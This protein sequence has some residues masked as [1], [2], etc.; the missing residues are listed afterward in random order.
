[1]AHQQYR[2]DLIFG[3]DTGQAINNINQLNTLLTSIQ[4]HTTVGIDG[5]SIQQAV[6]AAKE[7]QVHLNN[8]VNVNTG[9][10]DL[11]KFS[12]S[13][14]KAGTDLSTL[15]TK[16]QAAG[17]AGQQAFVKIANAVSQAQV[18]MYQ[19]SGAM[20][21]FAT[22]LLNT[23]K[24]Q[25]ASTAIHGVVGAIKSA[26][27]YT[28]DLNAALNDIQIV[29][30]AGEI[31]MSNFA[32]KAAEAARALNTT[33]TEYAKAAL[34]FYQQG[35]SGDAVLERTNTVIKLAQ[36]TGQSAAMVSDQMTAIWNN[37]DDGSKSLEHYADVLTKLG[38]STASSTD[39]ISVGLQKFAAVA[40]TVGLNYETAA[41]AVA[42]V[43]AETRQSAEVVG[44]S[45]K[46]IFARMESLKLGDTLED[47]VDLNKYTEALSAVGVN[48]LN[49]KGQLRDM[50]DILNELGTKWQG[51]SETT[52]IAL[53]QTVGGIRQYNQMIALMDNW[54]KVEENVEL[55]EN[56]GGELA[57]QAEIWSNSYEGAAE[58]LKQAKNDLYESLIDDST[59]IGF[60]NVMAGLINKI[61][62]FIDS[63]GGIGPVILMLVGLFSK[64]LLP[65]VTSVFTRAGNLISVTTGKALK[66]TIA[67]QEQMN[68]K[69]QESLNSGNYTGAQQE[70]LRLSNELLQVKQ[71]MV[72]AS[73]NASV[74][75]QKEMEA[76]VAAYEAVNLQTQ[77]IYEQI[78]A[79]ES[80]K[81][82]Q[83]G[84]VT[85][86][87]DRKQMFTASV[88]NKAREAGVSEETIQ[89]ATTT[90]ISDTQSKLANFN[91]A[92]YSQ[93]T[94]AIQSSIEESKKRINALIEE[95][96]LKESGATEEIRRQGVE[97][98]K[99]LSAEQENLNQLMAKKEESVK[100]DTE[101]RE[102]L[103]NI[104]QLQQDI[105]N[106]I[107]E[108][109]TTKT[110][111]ISVGTIKTQQIE[112]DLSYTTSQD[113][114]VQAREKQKAA[115]GMEV[116]REATQAAGMTGADSGEIDISLSN[117]EKLFEAIQKNKNALSEYKATM[118]D[119]TAMLSKTSKNVADASNTQKQASDRLKK[120][121]A[122]VNKL[123][124]Q[125][126]KSGKAYRAAKKEVAAAT[127]EY[128]A[129]EEKLKTVQE[130][131]KNE[132]LQSIEGF[133]KLASSMNLPKS[134][135]DE[136]DAKFKKLS[137]SEN[138]TEQDILEITSIFERAGVSATIA[139]D[140]MEL[141]SADMLKVLAQSGMSEEALLK[142]ATILEKMGAKG[143][144]AANMLRQLAGEFQKTQ[145]YSASMQ[146]ALTGAIQG[147]GT[148]AG[149]AMMAYTGFSMF[150]KIFD[151]SATPAEKF[152]NIMMS[153]SML[154]PIVA[155]SLKRI[156]AARKEENYLTVASI[157]AKTKENIQMAIANAQKEKGAALTIFE[158]AKIWLHNAAL[159]VKNIL[160][161]PVAGAIIVGIALATAAAIAIGTSNQEKYNEQLKKTNEMNMEQ[162]EKTNDLANAWSEQMD[163]MDN[164]IAK[165]EDLK[166]AGED[167]KDVVSDIV[168]QVP[169]MV[170]AYRDLAKGLDINVGEGSE[171]D[172][173][174]RRLE[175]AA[176][177]GDI[178]KIKEIQNELDNL[179][180][181]K[182]AENADKG[183]QS[184][185]IS[186]AMAMRDDGGASYQNNQVTKTVS[187]STEA[188]ILSRF[189]IGTQN[190]SN[191][192]IK[193]DADNASNFI[194]DYEN[195][196]KAKTE[197]ENTMGSNAVNS[198]AYQDIV[199]LLD[200]SSEQYD[201][202]T[203]LQEASNKYKVYEAKERLQRQ[204]EDISNIK[205][206]KD[207]REYRDKL[208]NEVGTDPVARQAAEDWLKA[209]EYLKE[210][211]DIESKLEYL[212]ETT[213]KDYT[214]FY[215]NLSPD[216]QKYFAQINFNEVQSEE[217]IRGEIERLRSIAAE[218]EIDIKIKGVGEIK[219]SVSKDMTMED[220]EAIRNNE[221]IGWG[222]DGIIQFEEFIQLSYQQQLDYLDKIEQEQQKRKSAELKQRIS[223]EEALLKEL[224][225][226]MESTTDPT[227]LKQ[228]NAEYER[229]FN[230]L[231]KD[232]DDDFL[233]SNIISN[234]ELNALE[235]TRSIL[236]EISDLEFGE[237]ISEEDYFNIVNYNKE[238]AKYFQLTSEGY[239]MVGNPL[240][241]QQEV[242]STI[243]E[244][245]K[246]II[247]ESKNKYLSAAVTAQSLS[248]Y[249]GQEKKEIGSHMTDDGYLRVNELY[250]M[251]NHMGIENS[252]NS[253]TGEKFKG[254][255]HWTAGIKAAED[256]GYE[257]YYDDDGNY[258]NAWKAASQDKQEATEALRGQGKED[259]I[260]SNLGYQ[261]NYIGESLLSN[262]SELIT[263]GDIYGSGVSK[264]MYTMELDP[265]YVQRTTNITKFLEQE[266]SK[267]VL[268]EENW[269][270]LNDY[271]WSA[272]NQNVTEYSGTIMSTPT[273]MHMDEESAYRNAGYTKD[274]EVA[275]FSAL[276]NYVNTVWAEESSKYDDWVEQKEEAT[277]AE[278][279]AVAASDAVATEFEN[280]WSTT[281]STWNTN[282]DTLD[283]AE[284]TMKDEFQTA[285]KY[286]NELFNGLKTA[287]ERHEAYQKEL[288]GLTDEQKKLLD[289]SN[290]LNQAYWQSSHAA[291]EQ[292]ASEGLDVA[293]WG[294]YATYLE[295][296]LNLKEQLA[297]VKIN[298]VLLEGEEL[299][300]YAEE[301][302][303]DAA[304]S[305]MKMNKGITTLSSNWKEWSKTLKAGNAENGKS[306]KNSQLY[307]KT[308]SDTKTALSDVLDVSEEFITM[309]FIT[310]AENLALIEKA[311]EGDAEAIDALGR[312]LSE[313]IVKQS[314]ALNFAEGET[315]DNIT[316]LLE[317]VSKALDDEMPSLSLA[318]VI[319]NE[320]V[321]FQKMQDVVTAAKMTME[322]ANAYYRSM[323][324]TPKYKV[325]TL[326]QAN[327]IPITK[328]HHSRIYDKNSKDPDTGEYTRWTDTEQVE[329]TT[330]S[331]SEFKTAF[332]SYGV[333]TADGQGTEP[334]TAEV[335]EEEVT[336]QTDEVES[337]VY[338]G[339]GSFSDL[340]SGADTSGDSSSSDSLEE[341]EIKDDDPYKEINDALDNV[342]DN[343]KKANIAMERLYGKDK[344]AAM[345][346]SVKYLQQEVDLLEQKKQIATQ[347]RDESYNNLTEH[348]A[349]SG[350]DGL[351]VKINAEGDIL[352]EDELRNAIDTQYNDYVA[353]V[354][355][356]GVISEDE[357]A[358]LDALDE[359]KD[360]FEEY[361][362]DYETYKEDVEDFIIEAG[363][364][365]NEIFAK[366][367]EIFA[368]DLELE[369]E[370][371]TIGLD[372]LEYK[373]GL[374]E[375]D[376][377][378][379]SEVAALMLGDLN[380]EYMGDGG[381]LGMYLQSLETLESK[382]KELDE[383]K[384][385]GK[386]TDEAYVEQLKNINAEYL[387]TLQNLDALDDFMMDY[388]GNTLAAAGEELAKYTDRMDH[389][390]N[391]LEHYKSM[392]DLLGKSNDYEAM[393][394][395]LEGQAK[396]AE[397]AVKVSKANYE[398]L[399]AQTADWKEKMDKAVEGSEEWELYKKN[400]EA[401]EEAAREAEEQMLSDAEAWAES[402]KA[403][404][405][406]D[407]AKEFSK[408]EDQL[409]GGIGF[410]ELNKK[411]E[412]AQSLQEEM[413]TTTNKIYETN[414]MMREAEKAIDN[415]TN[416]VAKKKLQNF[417][418]E[419][420]LMQEQG[421][422]SQYELE[423]QQA[424]YD[425]LLAEIALEEAQNAKS[426]V[427]L[428]RDSEGN[429]G[430]VYTAEEDTVADAEQGVEDAENA[431]YNKSLEGIN[432]Y[433][434]KY[435][436]T[437]QAYAEEMNAINEAY[438]A[439]EY[440]THEEYMAARTA[441]EEY[442]NKQLAQFA[443][444]RNF[445]LSA[446]SEESW[447]ITMDMYKTK[448]DI[449]KQYE[450]GAIANEKEYLR[451]M[452][453]ANEDYSK[454][455]KDYSE[456]VKKKQ[457]G[458]SG[459]VR[460]AWAT[461]FALEQKSMKEIKDAVG[462]YTT[463][464]DTS[465]NNWK[466]KS[467][468]A[469]KQ[470]GLN[471]NPATGEVDN[472]GTK[473]GEVT[474]E[475]EDLVLELT[476][477]G[478]V[479]DAQE[480]AIDA[481]NREA[482]AYGKVR[483]VLAS[484]KGEALGAVDAN[485]A[486]IES[487][488]GVEKQKTDDSDDNVDN[489]TNES[490]S[491]NSNQNTTNSTSTSGNNTSSTTT[492][493][494]NIATETVELLE[495]IHYGHFGVGG[496]IQPAR[497]A[498]YSEDAIGI[499]LQALND[500]L[501][502]DGY[503]Y[504]YDKAL[505]LIQ[506][507]DTGGYTG[508]W[509]QA[510]K[511]AVLHEKELVLNKYDTENLLQAIQ[512]LREKSYDLVRHRNDME[513]NVDS[514]IA[515]LALA[516]QE[517]QFTKEQY[518]NLRE[519][520]ERDYNEDSQM[521]EDEI[522]QINQM[523]AQA[524]LQYAEMIMNEE[525]SLDR[526]DLIKNSVD[527]V[528]TDLGSDVSAYYKN[529]IQ[530]L[531]NNI[532]EVKTINSN[533][534]NISTDFKSII[535][536]ALDRILKFLDSSA[537]F[538]MDNKLD[539]NLG[540][541]N[542]VDKKERDV[543]QQ[544][545]S[546]NVEFPNV[547]NS[548]EIER[549][550]ENIINEAAQYAYRR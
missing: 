162:A 237:F 300:K 351:S 114:A 185:M 189:N 474:D 439:G 334:E 210:Y 66:E 62:D 1:M 16:L 10:L 330:I 97:A 52:Q 397:N 286:Y 14:K 226:K 15:T 32:S 322:Q 179:L 89:T 338:N 17:P 485:N 393:G 87:T 518:W 233:L 241:Y 152:T 31:Q 24:W 232:R 60:N 370:I 357:Q 69:M 63:A 496:W 174:I 344:I 227:E 158:T 314:I 451:L 294:D 530:K 377:Y 107:Q 416:S 371:H 33:T 513:N 533:I 500:S 203:E 380:S 253:A 254:G 6:N 56:A 11:S 260:E 277:E 144:E 403:I 249:K 148:L 57:K 246:E 443:Y 228:L 525:Y 159:A 329:S 251:Q 115:G 450:S 161:N 505:E 479:L 74:A 196:L 129:T 359:Y 324:F 181:P 190:G 310:T 347:K 201:K 182:V 537:I 250:A 116:F 275:A 318:D 512:M 291:I 270:L 506:G 36:V 529:S 346:D 199:K 136:L 301:A 358:Q 375:D 283:T 197:I 409:T 413:L 549:A 441:A 412:R 141:M 120:A 224:Q 184:A 508:A 50:E 449:Q 111:N 223:E 535:N 258:V 143:Q 466:T 470:M 335:E 353:Q 287:A 453:E 94:L 267:E 432:N 383:L 44:T 328:T 406:N 461:D 103:Q 83:E 447:Q 206:L 331:G 288:E 326:S 386:I 81:A 299:A 414:K 216:D 422:L 266:N 538:N 204:G 540:G 265:E 225:E 164:L 238:L 309:D 20:K 488:S 8:A 365:Q 348:I 242:R 163:T 7:L 385:Q 217:A 312:A 105:N 259:W 79:L 55:A 523:I 455:I 257:G 130:Q 127:K 471:V 65:I 155:G 98:E 171:F 295:E 262:N 408:L 517:G 21:T 200:A 96:K 122:E 307:V 325:T 497:N 38:A 263:S 48:V 402:L 419:T 243:N 304:Q 420:K 47:G 173:L 13:L 298:G 296:S 126:I 463:N 487:M 264:G 321:L 53:A 77:K 459:A 522:A 460:D 88:T 340:G 187:G 423:T 501:E 281:I 532:E 391:K 280:V 524:D 417:V 284:T 421:E 311:A 104:L 516:Y 536:G 151:E 22:T 480:K 384:A 448:A 222:K 356:D 113:P 345:K 378:K 407:L 128:T 427:T 437:A 40:E 489:N 51:F 90:K 428:Q 135:L 544:E 131:Q 147:I 139:G 368:Q 548:G 236:V 445:A 112:E 212:K 297:D 315:V 293:E 411:Y 520:I 539:K 177:A 39:E 37:F 388:Y 433:T 438:A 327:S 316:S 502:G 192:T 274:Q 465:F 102:Q 392:L 194:E 208:L 481:A 498:G 30:H 490:N 472:L 476:K 426:T 247:T 59:L 188:N 457:T 138:V 526:L 5:G 269:Q 149:Q 61:T 495:K 511:L 473:V 349:N 91:G 25:L 446:D 366:N 95:S 28:K 396:N 169:D 477:P 99:N 248:M 405:E 93:E 499:A 306:I 92:G 137:S 442:Y 170:D 166:E 302:A 483:D 67:L 341:R 268:G 507:Y 550:L 220:W 73:K 394:E 41:A 542:L 494:S 399:A 415:T 434:Q 71:R 239:K 12:M 195:L 343:A 376:M 124:S 282:I 183:A 464:I 352:N 361:F 214:T 528:V 430:Y 337:F 23:A 178:D 19:F 76:R 125:G 382:Q 292:E 84:V 395:I 240:D 29:T 231:E 456:E 100:K 289:E 68:Q 429:Y 400:W 198:K 389:Q 252:V 515:Q 145:G 211:A 305:I 235:N 468:E 418:N 134:T 436:E 205:S 510:G 78:Q 339:G 86:T 207:Y 101:Q 27:G 342:A 458:D 167:Y 255:D 3:A 435:Q 110:S 72:I 381:Q 75:E 244:I 475:Y 534:E 379:V 285:Q 271:A 504:C 219:D 410:D 146:G 140:S 355:A 478:G 4:K 9:A 308:L 290:L 367:A 261:V 444:L 85:K 317:A 123:E 545:V 398:M 541:S 313:D 118:S 278:A 54:T 369:L 133:K 157:I 354:K 230:E 390:N 172:N 336:I 469:A 153:L 191:F 119:Y 454:D 320:D 387:A 303:E 156:N 493:A 425:L 213:G 363:E 34:I 202:L 160:Q 547:T 58:R 142:L 273:D 364:K 64:S 165:Y 186:T 132:M 26:I 45:F 323:G 109:V 256:A 373:L 531:S 491:N 82:A 519:S 245:D 492:T 2:V 424:R 18:P 108:G 272:K 467:A 221:N 43:V 319:T 49:A 452:N 486:L 176:A 80:E 121:Q 546:I 514:Q 209:N 482:T 279:A 401:A 234:N 350:I 543:L 362:D 503:A 360:K 527:S 150:M 229:I 509:G 154:L 35:L 404:L 42:T 180:S 215:N 440:A 175:N 332:P 106:A 521:I 372:V 276:G 193:L 484:I 70:Q 168:D 218:E 374:I 117:L 333:K 431:L 46:T 462:T